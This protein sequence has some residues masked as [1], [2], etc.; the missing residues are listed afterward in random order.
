MNLPEVEVVG[1][2]PTQALFE[3][4]HGER[5]VASVRTYLGH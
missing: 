4:L 5:G 2:Q 3:H 1:L